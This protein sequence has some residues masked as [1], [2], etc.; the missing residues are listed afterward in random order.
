MNRSTALLAK[1]GLFVC[2]VLAGCSDDDVR[3]IPTEGDG[4]GSRY[5][6]F[7]T[8][9]TADERM[10]YFALTPSLDGDVPIDIARGIEEPGG[11]RLYVQP[12]VGTFL[13]GGGEAPTLTRYELN[14]EGELERGQSLSFANQGVSDLA[15]SA[16]VFVSPSKAYFRDRS[17]VQLVSF[18]P[19][20]MEILNTFPL[21]GL[22]R[23]GFITDFGTSVFQRADGIYFPM[24]WYDEAEDSAPAGAALVRVVP[25][26]DTIEIT[27]DPR[28]S[29]L[30]VGLT[31]AQGD[32]YWFST[33]TT[34]WWRAPV[35]AGLPRDCAL[36]VRRDEQTFDPSWELD[37]TTRTNGWPSVAT[38]AGEGSKIWLRVLEESEVRVP[39]DATPDVVEELQGWQWY[40][41]DVEANA[42][43]QR[44]AERQSG[45]Y[46]AY[47]FQVDGRT[48]TTESDA[49]YTQSTLL[50]LREQGFV[51]GATVT[52]TV[53]GLARLR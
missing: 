22:E 37:T 18:D 38:V 13:L 45:S 4:N 21:E 36:R 2:L 8:V 11:G 5:V 25:E 9:D 43:A 14:A 30:S 31:S 28:C 46:Y 27:T 33:R 47:G 15:D 35:N 50:E 6:V 49:E 12:G 52:G 1:K 26:T 20:R 41:L 16:V 39:A 7:S 32:M 34:T 53:R 44:N 23:A 48:Y 3:V 42:P 24:M 29:G 10:G 40:L 17:Q 19:T 51:E